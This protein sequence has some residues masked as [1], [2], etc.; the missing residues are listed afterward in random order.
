MHITHTTAIVEISALTIAE[1]TLLHQRSVPFRRVQSLIVFFP[2]Q[3]D[4]YFF[5]LMTQCPVKYNTEM[6]NQHFCGIGF[7]LQNLLYLESS[8]RKLA[9]HRQSRQT[10]VFGAR[11]M[12]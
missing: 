6:K 8:G 3:A 12:Y 9:L 11:L 2:A 4:K 1:A 5:K 10:A 7:Q